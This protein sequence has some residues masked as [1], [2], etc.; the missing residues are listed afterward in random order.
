MASASWFEDIIE[1]DSSFYDAYVGVGTYY[2]WS[3]RK[4]AFIRWLPFIKDYRELGISMLIAGAE[5]SEYN[6]FAAVSALISIY[7]DAE[8]YKMAEKWS[9]YGLKYYPENRIFLWGIATALDRQKCFK[10]AVA[11]Y[12]YLLDK[13]LH[14]QSGNLYGE[15][16]CRLNLAKS[17][18][19][20]EDTTG[21]INQLETLSAYWSLT[22]PENYDPRITS[23]LNRA[24]DLFSEIKNQRK[25][26]K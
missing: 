3:S 10:D 16:V 1:K 18:L 15:I 2:Y 4:T 24:M 12:E 22:F 11:A 7:L 26:S 9:R 23:K 17:K 21:A 5:H 14:A 6:R 8:E 20:I 19:A 13:I 25:L